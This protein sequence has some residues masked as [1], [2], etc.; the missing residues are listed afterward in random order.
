MDIS[1]WEKAMPRPSL[2]GGSLSWRTA[3][4]MALAFGGEGIQSGTSRLIAFV[5]SLL[6][7]GNHSKA[8]KPMTIV[9]LLLNVFR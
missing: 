3:H 6:Q 7:M 2:G 5:F 4:R 9:L 8:P 1:L